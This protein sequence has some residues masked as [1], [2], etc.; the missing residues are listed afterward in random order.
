MIERHGSLVLLICGVA[1]GIGGLV[2]GD[3]TVEIGLAALG[4]SLVVLAVILTRTEGQ[5]KIGPSGL[6]ASLRRTATERAE[7]VGTT[8]AA[9]GLGSLTAIATG[10]VSLNNAA[11]ADKIRDGLTSL[12]QVVEKLD[13]TQPSREGPVPA[14]VLLETARGLMASGEWG[15]AADYLDRYIEIEPSNWDAQFSRAIAHA[16]TR[17]GAKSDLASLRAYN[18][19]LALR[20]PDVDQNL[21]AR[22]FS[23]RA[24]ML[25][26][27]G[28]LGEAEADLHLAQSLATREYERND[29]EYNLACV[30]AMSGRRAEAMEIISA[31]AGTPWGGSIRANLHRYFASLEDD[32]DF[33]ALLASL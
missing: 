32:P 30:Y 14:S 4:A 33:L 25:K 1:L 26:R 24:G 29:I 16:N 21:V 5:V 17:G 18:D 11:D 13:A 23:Y 12:L 6:E 10:E 31:L 27:L 8:L 28:R 20:D 7:T 15:K 2:A 3:A 9:S 22:L 19:A